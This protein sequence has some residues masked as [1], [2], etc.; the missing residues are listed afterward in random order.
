[1]RRPPRASRTTSAA[2]A[3]QG[4]ASSGTTMESGA[5]GVGT[6]LAGRAAAVVVIA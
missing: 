1:M 3:A 2:N 4:T 6:S 5:S